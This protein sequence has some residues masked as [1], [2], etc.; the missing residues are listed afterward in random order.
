M[1]DLTGSVDEIGGFVFNAAHTEFYTWYQYG[2]SAGF[3]GS[4]VYRYGISGTTVT[5]IAATEIGYPDFMR[6]P[7][8]TSYNVCY[9]K[10]LRRL[11]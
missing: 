4:N 10:L 5:Q 3:A 1:T 2:L 9:T 7:R 11:Q 8:I 6:D